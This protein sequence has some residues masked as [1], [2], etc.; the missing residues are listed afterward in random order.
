M[1]IS[2]PHLQRVATAQLGQGKGM[3]LLMR[4]EDLLPLQ[5]GGPAQWQLT[6]LNMIFDGT[7]QTVDF[8]L[9]SLLNRP[10]QERRTY[11]FQA[12]L[13]EDTSELDNSDPDNLQRLKGLG[14]DFVKRIQKQVN[15][16]QLYGQLQPP[17]RPRFLSLT[18]IKRLW[19]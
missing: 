5:A 16:Q 15:L 1:V 14:S 12:E 4:E 6:P 13:T 2:S 18:S 3:V 11:R 9:N 7:S 17:S 19:F 8:Q 10:G